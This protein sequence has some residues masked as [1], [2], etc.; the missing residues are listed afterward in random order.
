MLLYTA[1]MAKHRKAKELNLFFL[2]TTVKSGHPSFAPTWDMVLG[3]KEHK[4]TWEEYTKLYTERMRESWAINKDDW[5]WLMSQ[6]TLVLA[7]YCNDLATCHC[8]RFL[9][10]DMVKVIGER[11][12]IEVIDRGE[13]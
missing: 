8:H 9:L 5:K 7:C 11:Y 6:E 4:L 1:Q 3:F 13:L 10:R 2:D 12:G